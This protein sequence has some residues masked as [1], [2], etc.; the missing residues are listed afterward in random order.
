MNVDRFSNAF[1]FGR[2]QTVEKEV[3]LT[4]L[5]DLFSRGYR[6]IGASTCIRAARLA[7]CPIGVPVCASP[8]WIERTTTSPVYPTRACSGNRFC[9]M[10]S[11]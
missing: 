8:V 6:A 4:E 9:R 11:E 10:R 1:D 2:T 3:A 5:P 7:V